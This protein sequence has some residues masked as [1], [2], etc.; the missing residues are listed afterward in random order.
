MIPHLSEKGYIELH[1]EIMGMLDVFRNQI[2]NAAVNKD[3]MRNSP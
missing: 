3:Y 1:T 2:E